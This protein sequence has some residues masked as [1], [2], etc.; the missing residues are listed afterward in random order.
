MIKLYKILLLTHDEQLRGTFTK[1]LEL[2]ENG[3]ATINRTKL[4]W[5]QNIRS[6]DNIPLHGNTNI[7]IN[8]N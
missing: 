5:K 4:F 6:V 7:N 2:F 3:L 8:S 1:K